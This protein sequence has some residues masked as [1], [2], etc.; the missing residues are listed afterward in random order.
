MTKH[1]L[2]L[3][4]GK[5]GLS[6]AYYLCHQNANVVLADT[7][8]QVSGI[9]AFKKSFPEVSVSLGGLPLS[10]LDNI[11]TLV[12]SPGLSPEQPI[13]KEALRR[14]IEVIGD[15]ELFCRHAYSPIIAVTGTNAKST[16][17][18]LIAKMIADA[19]YR[20]GLGGNIGTPALALLNKTKDEADF[21]VLEL[22]SFQL[23]STSSLKAKV[24][25]VLNI[26]PDHMDRYDSFDDYVN[27]KLRIFNGCENALYNHDDDLTIPRNNEPVKI[28]FGIGKN[29]KQT[30]LSY[31][32]NQNVASTDLLRGDGV[33]VSDDMLQLKGTHNHLNCLAAIA[34]CD[35]IGIERSRQRK[36]LQEFS[37]LPH[38]CE[39]IADIHGVS[40]VNDSKGTNVGATLAAL[41]GFGKGF[42]KKIIL[43]LGGVSKDASFS[44]LINPINQFVKR[45]LVYGQDAGK[46]IADLSGAVDCQ[47][48]E[49][50]EFEAVISKAYSI[51]SE[52]DLVLFSPA[53]ASFDMF[54][55]FEHRGEVFKKQVLAFAPFSNKE[56]GA[57]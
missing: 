39:T 55:S 54:D 35:A 13:V 30:A 22:S 21:Y 1:Y 10:L 12:I 49:L 9:D 15:I 17:V 50:E 23:E 34:V 45:I 56:R 14:D 40:W 43:I 52:Q 53:C 48:D 36:S 26:T 31:S 28:S 33:I 20:V 5:S 32:L 37:G 57:C 41:K 29:C 11:D 8:E 44:S 25:V 3:G 7:R 18:T 42:P 4:L 51:A 6:A 27:T 24:A 16:V 2:I 46:I 47:I 19:G 38:R